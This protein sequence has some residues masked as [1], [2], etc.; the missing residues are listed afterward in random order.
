MS[1]AHLQECRF[2]L[3]GN[4]AKGSSCVFRH[5]S[6]GTRTCPDWVRGACTTAGCRYRHAHANQARQTL[7]Q[8]PVPPTP[9]VKH[10]CI[11][12]AQ[13]RCRF[14]ADCMYLHD[15]SSKARPE[16]PE[17]P[18][19]KSSTS[20]AL[21]L[22][23]LVIKDGSPPRSVF[24]SFE[25]PAKPCT[26]M[27]TTSTQGA[28]SK[29]KPRRSKFALALSAAAMEASTR[30][31][32]PTRRSPRH[33]KTPQGGCLL[34]Q[35]QPLVSKKVSPRGALL[36][37]E[38]R[39]KMLLS[40]KQKGAVDF[41]QR[42]PTSNAGIKKPSP[43]KAP[44][45]PKQAK[46][47]LLTTA[48]QGSLRVQPKNMK[49]KTGKQ[50]LSQ[51]QQMLTQ[52]HNSVKAIKPGGNQK[53]QQQQQSAQ[54]QRQVTVRPSKTPEQVP[55]AKKKN[56]RNQP[57]KQ[58]NKQRKGPPQQHTP[59]VPNNNAVPAGA[60]KTLKGARM[61]KQQG[62][63]AATPPNAPQRQQQQQPR[64]A[65]ANLPQRQQSRKR[66]ASDA[67]DNAP[68]NKPGSGPLPV[69]RT[70][71]ELQA[72]EKAKA[73]AANGSPQAATP[74]GPAN[75]ETATT[76]SPQ[77]NSA[78]ASPPRKRKLVRPTLRRFS[79]HTTQ[80]PTVAR[81]GD[82]VSNVGASAPS[83][84]SASGGTSVGTSAP[85]L[86]PGLPDGAMPSQL[87]PRGTSAG[88]SFASVVGARPPPASAVSG[89]NSVDGSA[90]VDA[91]QPIATPTPKMPE[92]K[93]ASPSLAQPG[94]TTMPEAKTTFS[95]LPQPG[96]NGTAASISVDASASSAPVDAS[97]SA[98]ADVP[99]PNDRWRA[100][101]S[102]DSL[103][104]R[105]DSMIDL[106]L[107]Q[108][109]PSSATDVL[110]SATDVDPDPSKLTFLETTSLSLDKELEDLEK[111]LGD[112]APSVGLSSTGGCSQMQSSLAFSGD[113]F[114]EDEDL[115]AALKEV[116]EFEVA[117]E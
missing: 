69:V 30:S 14:G 35:A 40:L 31:R 95:S 84:G 75:A 47:K 66:S 94:L 43:Q 101:S 36:E 55:E 91:A 99:D 48:P 116:A 93:T 34:E 112:I 98:D 52:D 103:R 83:A 22:P 33:P 86:A 17:N 70:L 117:A 49:P 25:T 61:G 74:G 59:H 5:T 82:G 27:N 96:L 73:A 42:T 54:T 53:Q 38:L 106:E 85:N 12:F 110:S 45:P 1:N 92:A 21:P 114:I 23:P 32:T 2:F 102:D 63:V 77:S 81:T 65:P 6:E 46:R 105:V 24:A 58:Q 62:G 67:L 11:Y 71:E 88:D 97:S 100:I 57:P 16:R 68:K 113:S 72:A 89:G 107:N 41:K 44:T 8:K 4:C 3:Q 39:A 80:A 28:Q 19:P 60:S 50:R 9:T 37:N 109:P 78:V 87:P 15:S 79:P 90:C 108:M 104:E 111:S 51:L 115:K 7:P 13:G 18:V 20:P 64:I 26:T 29:T 10:S 56:P 76:A